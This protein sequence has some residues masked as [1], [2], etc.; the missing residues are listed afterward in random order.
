MFYKLKSDYVLRGWEEMSW[1]LVK[2]P[3]N[4]TRLMSQKMFQVLLLCDGETELP[5]ELLDDT[6]LE[7]LHKCESEGI[8]EAS[9]QTSPLDRSSFTPSPRTL[10]R[11]SAP[12]I[13]SG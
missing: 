1:V 11:R 13:T 12:S 3:E 10:S 4:A 6:L 5:G 2:R 8:I 7:V 9:V